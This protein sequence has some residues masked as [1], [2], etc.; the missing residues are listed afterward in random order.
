MLLACRL[1]F[2]S[3]APAT[4][5][6]RVL[7]LV[8]YGKVQIRLSRP[9]KR[10]SAAELFAS[11]LMRDILRSF[12]VGPAS[13]RGKGGKFCLRSPQPSNPN[14]ELLSRVGRN[15]A[16]QHVPLYFPNSHKITS[17]YTTSRTEIRDLI[18][19]TILAN[20]NSGEPA[21]LAT[22][23]MRHLSPSSNV[24]IPATQSSFKCLKVN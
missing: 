4:E 3:G 23:G 24:L 14:Y 22:S 18:F 21:T 1:R 6:V 17:H 8:L 13:K 16:Q 15:T 12:L 20:R 19:W 9:R 11:T 2:G 7:V 5:P 10:Q